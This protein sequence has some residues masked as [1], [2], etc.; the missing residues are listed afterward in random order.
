MSELTIDEARKRL[1]VSPQ[2][3]RALLRAGELEGRQLASRAWLVDE[4]ALERRIALK[5]TS[6]RNWSAL[7]SWALLAELSAEPQL[8]VISERTRARV[9]E[10]IRQ[11][12]AEEI[13]RRVSGRTKVARYDADD[14]F[15]AGSDMVS[16]GGSAIDELDSDLAP[17]FSTIEGYVEVDVMAEFVREH[18]LIP[19]KRGFIEIYENPG[20]FDSNR[21][22]APLAVI[23]ADLARSTATRERTAGLRALEQMRQRWLATHTR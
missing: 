8:V 12:S 14:H 20:I 21:S 2:H 18:M 16:T 1:D 11:C 10:R 22:H 5:A 6:G 7:S 17:E 3:V 15:S 19:D 4:D 23:A 9:R 13:A